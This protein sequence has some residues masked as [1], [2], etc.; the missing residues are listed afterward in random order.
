MPCHR[1][2]GSTVGYAAYLAHSPSQKR[3]GTDPGIKR[4]LNGIELAYLLEPPLRVS[5]VPLRIGLR[6]PL[7]RR[8]PV[9]WG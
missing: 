3:A 7:L 8:C 5:H 2:I 4:F 9:S 1:P 6:I